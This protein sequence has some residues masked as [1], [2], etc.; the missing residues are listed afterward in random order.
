V[1]QRRMEELRETYRY[2]QTKYR[3]LHEQFTTLQKSYSL[4][5]CAWCKRRI[6]WRRQAPAVP[7]AISHGICPPCA[8]RLLTQL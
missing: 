6:R 7:G 8:A 5:E 1:M 3:A 2:F 4:I